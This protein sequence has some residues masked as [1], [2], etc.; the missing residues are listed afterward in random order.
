MSFSRV[1]PV[2]LL[3]GD[4]LVKTINFKK[5]TYI[6]DPI[7]A[8]K[9]FNQKE[10]DELVLL[11]I[12]AST[13][14]Y[15][16]RY[17]WIQDIVSESFM[18]IGYGGGIKNIE[19]V[20]KI[21]DLGVEKIILNTSSQDLDLISKAASIYGSQSIV[22]SIDVKKSLLGKKYCYFKGGK[23][24]IKIGAVE[25]AKK[26]VES[27]VGEIIIQSID[28]EGTMKGY[29]IELT[30]EVSE[31]V[32]VPVVASGGAGNINDVEKVLKEGK[33][34][35]AAAGSIFVYKGK[36]KGVLINYPTRKELDSISV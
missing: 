11:D 23:D 34:S 14:N 29:D 13:K 12:E 33:A 36:Q 20:K 35:A 7:N 31:A 19:Q 22:A 24:K 4:G 21:F 16:P 6:G 8:V 32:N 27:G 28:L 10:V 2:L 5:P 1:I 25:W 30:R 9:I 17:E 3:K 18:P 15:E 26:L